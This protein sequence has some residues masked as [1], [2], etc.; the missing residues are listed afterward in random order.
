[1]T[2]RG[3]G[4][5]LR[6]VESGAH[7]LHVWIANHAA[8]WGL[9]EGQQRAVASLIIIL[10]AIVISLVANLV[11]KRFIVRAVEAII[12]RTE[13]KW[14]DLILERHVFDNLSHL[15]PGV[16]LMAAAP[17][18]FPYWPVLE[19]TFQRGCL[20]YMGVVTLMVID[21][22]L[23]AI[24]DIYQRYDVSQTRPIK[25]YIQVVKIVA[26]VVGA[27][28]LISTIIGKSPVVLLSGLGALSAVLLL[29]FKDSILGLVASVQLG[30]YDM[31]RKGDWIEVPKFGADGDVID[32]SLTTVKVQNFDKTISTIP[33][34]ALISDSFRN[35]R[36]MSESGGRRI[37]RSVYLDMN[38]VH[39]LTDERLDEL[40]GIELISDYI[41]ARRDEVDQYNEENKV[42]TSEQIN[43]R[44]LTN[45]GTFR[46]YVKAY[47]QSH[48]DIHQDMT[49]LV[50]QLAP[51]NDGVGIELYC[52]TNVTAWDRYESIQA[53]IFDHLLSAV[54]KFG[55][56]VFQNPAGADFRRL[57]S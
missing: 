41:A 53:D 36:G 3:G 22:A 9:P 31:I 34:Y 48:P 18:A 6:A 54:P 15:A 13:T 49:L 50:R 33:T 20:V 8:A 16:V 35:W 23:S 56:S 45:L 27:I 12:K 43:G 4:S 29:V 46:A 42:D 52:F 17:L 51:G 40:K 25:S 10:A 1:M 14:D 38:S 39:F 11:A 55:L 24:V 2:P 30:G 47:L 5:T 28:L 7:H 32:I 21:G 37:K 57:A 19:N 44:R 26:Y